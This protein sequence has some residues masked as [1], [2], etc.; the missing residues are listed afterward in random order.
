MRVFF[1]SVVL[2]IL[3]SPVIVHGVEFKAMSSGIQTPKSSSGTSAL[4]ALQMPAGQP[5]SNPSSI[6]A[7]VTD[8]YNEVGG[9]RKKH[10]RLG[11]AIV[12]KVENLQ[13]LKRLEVANKKIILYLNDIPIKGLQRESVNVSTGELRFL[14]IRD[15]RTKGSLD[16]LICKPRLEVPATI[17]VGF[18]DD[19]S[20]PTAVSGRNGMSFDVINPWG[21]AG[22]IMFTAAIAYLFLH[23]AK[24]TSLLR[25]AGLDSC[26]SLAHSQMA[27]WTLFICSG[28][29]L[30]Y[31]ITLEMPDLN[32]SMLILLGLSAGTALGGKVIDAGKPV[33]K[34]KGKFLE[35]ILQDADG[36]TVARLQ[37][38]IWTLVMAGIFISNVYSK[39]AMPEFGG[40]LLALMG[41]SSGTYLG[42]KIPEAKVPVPPPT[43]QM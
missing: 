35:D 18:E 12:V 36:Y 40:T 17:T 10:F 9:K 13:E 22:W 25:T 27:F 2:W 7:H 15:E 4:P 16:Q 3:L 38:F 34:T 26:F 5:M 19:F 6:N 23:L 29:V 11:S 41:I 24:T 32:S 14:I 39:L 28:Y 37:I 1:K 33:P 8:A 21:L 30:I 43:P 42:F 31:L 20:I